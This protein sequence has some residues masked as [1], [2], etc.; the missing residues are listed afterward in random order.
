M[1]IRLLMLSLAL[2][3]GGCATRAVVA[4]RMALPADMLT[5]PPEPSGR[6]VTDDQGVATYATDL[7]AAG[8]TC[9][10]HLDAARAALQSEH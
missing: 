3:L 2:A 1:M 8:R 9:R 10:A 6:G 7:A 5:C 4:P